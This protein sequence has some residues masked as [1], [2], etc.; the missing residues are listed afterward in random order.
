MCKILSY[1]IRSEH[2]KWLG[3]A[4]GVLGELGILGLEFFICVSET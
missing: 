2:I 3:G 1:Q 4:L